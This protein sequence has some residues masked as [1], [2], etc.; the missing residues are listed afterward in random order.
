MLPCDTAQVGGLYQQGLPGIQ[1]DIEQTTVGTRRSD[2]IDRRA[3]DAPGPAML[4]SGLM[5]VCDF[6]HHRAAVTLLS[7]K[8]ARIVS[9]E[10]GQHLTTRE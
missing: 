10:T 1:E 4:L 8:V 3:H 6:D 7:P 2:E 5:G 9:A